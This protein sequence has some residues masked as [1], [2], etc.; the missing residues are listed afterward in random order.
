MSQFTISL[1][2]NSSMDVYP[3]NTMSQFT[4]KLS[5]FI[6][7]DVKWEVGLLEASFPGKVENVFNDQYHYTL[8]IID[9][10]NVGEGDDDDDDKYNTIN[11]EYTMMCMMPNGSMH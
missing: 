3:N 8:T 4:T 5:E 11:F 9:Y 7:F 10:N 2:S 6:E 1:P